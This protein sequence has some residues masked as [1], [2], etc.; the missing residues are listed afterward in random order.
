M[1]ESV[2]M[3]GPNDGNT[4]LSNVNLDEFFFVSL[5]SETCSRKESRKSRSGELSLLIVCVCVPR[6][7]KVSL[8]LM[9][10]GRVKVNSDKSRTFQ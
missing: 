9:N 4:G 8:V 2:L 6:A 3:I 7:G 5:V 1:T 10:P